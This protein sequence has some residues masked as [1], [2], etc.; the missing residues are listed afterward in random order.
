MSKPISIKDRANWEAQTG[1]RAKPRRTPE[2]L[3]EIDRAIAR[4]IEARS[5]IEYHSALVALGVTLKGATAIRTDGKH[6]R[7]IGLWSNGGPLRQLFDRVTDEKMRVSGELKYAEKEKTIVEISVWTDANLPVQIAPAGPFNAVGEDAELR[8]V[9]RNL[10]R[11]D[12]KHNHHKEGVCSLA[13]IEHVARS[14]LD[15]D[16]FWSPG[17]RC[18]FISQY[19]GIAG[20]NVTRKVSV[21]QDRR[22][23]IDAYVQG[24]FH[25]GF[26]E[27]ERTI[28]H[29]VKNMGDGRVADPTWLQFFPGIKPQGR[30]PS[31]FTGT[32]A[33]FRNLFA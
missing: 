29:T 4:C 24:V 15:Q 21:T 6:E 20:P 10:V 23:Q 5:E 32:E 1:G 26:V 12:L 14:Y 17:Q 30:F 25:K 31:I 2:T 16:K 13:L 3:Q 18:H 33:D 27:G 7:D 22:T 11:E 9:R 28:E 8:R 19:C